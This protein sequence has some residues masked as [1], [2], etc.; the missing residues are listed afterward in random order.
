MGYNIE[1]SYN[2]IKHSSVTEIQNNI[3]GLA[4][5]CSCNFFYE[6]YEFEYN[7]CYQRKHCIITVNLDNL[8]TIK[9]VKRIKKIDGLYIESI[10]DDF[11]NMILYASKY[12]QTQKMSKGC[13]NE[14]KQ[15]KRERSYSEDDTIILNTVK[16]PAR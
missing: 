12:Y 6:D 9:F 3:K 11:S 5:E 2:I 8:N 15:E 10:Y 1:I 4:E 16:T 7:T 13:V 14:Y